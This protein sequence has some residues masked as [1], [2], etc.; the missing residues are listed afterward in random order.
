MVKHDPRSKTLTILSKAITEDLIGE[1]LLFRI[2]ASSVSDLATARSPAY[3][4]LSIQ[5]EDPCV[6]SKLEMYQPLGVLQSFELNEK[7]ETLA[8][9]GL[10]LSPYP[11]ADCGSFAYELK[12]PIENKIKDLLT[13]LPDGSA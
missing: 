5:I 8:L 12:Q 10:F 4:S 11:V 7:T 13:L 1:I 3:L 6:H 2:A 9:P